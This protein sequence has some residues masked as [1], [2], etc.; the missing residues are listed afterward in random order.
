[1]LDLS[2]KNPKYY[3]IRNTDKGQQTKQ[4]SNKKRHSNLH[5]FLAFE[6]N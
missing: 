2:L 6:K 3:D 4:P 1:M 5:C